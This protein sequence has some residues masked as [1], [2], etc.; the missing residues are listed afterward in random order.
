M[1]LSL[2][3]DIR[4]LVEGEDLLCSQ[5]TD[6]EF[7]HILWHHHISHV[8]EVGVAH[9]QLIDPFLQVPLLGCRQLLIL[10]EFVHDFGLDELHLSSLLGVGEEELV[11]HVT[12]RNI[13]RRWL[14][15]STF[16]ELLDI[17]VNF[18]L[19]LKLMGET[20]LIFILMLQFEQLFVNLL[21][22]LFSEFPCL[23]HFGMVSACLDD[24]I[25]LL[26][27]LIVLVRL[28]LFGSFLH[29]EVRIRVQRL[30]HAL[31]FQELTE[32]SWVS[33]EELW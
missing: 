7:G 28:I 9:V 27:L 16:H 24:L 31:C 20:C 22:H 17:N 12:I 2:Q 19:S 33:F 26:N 14:H 13:R 5:V 4:N 30:G 10:A 25:K 6:L 32:S 23:K 15:F 11:R 29:E 1:L 18:D 3:I 21:H 8:A